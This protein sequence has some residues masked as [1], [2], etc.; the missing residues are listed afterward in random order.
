MNKT[1][2]PDEVSVITAGSIITGLADGDSISIERNEDTFTL[3]VGSQGD[4]TRTRNA[5]KSGRI[6]LTLQ[7]TSESNEVLQ[8][9]LIADEANGNGF[10][11]ILIRDNSG[12]DLHV[13][14]EA[15]IVRQPSAAYGKESGTREWIIETGS[16]RSFIGG[17]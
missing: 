1:Y 11:P 2:L 15:W 9:L 4:T 7:Q 16:L 6:T 14:E 12:K 5:N 3:A 10:F 17:N 8:N 13:A